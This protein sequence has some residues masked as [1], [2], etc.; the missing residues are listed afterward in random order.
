MIDEVEFEMLIINKAIEK[1]IPDI[2]DKE[3]GYV[4]EKGKKLIKLFKELEGKGY[5]KAFTRQEANELRMK[6]AQA[7]FNLNE[8]KELYLTLYKLLMNNQKNVKDTKN[9]LKDGN[10]QEYSITMN[11]IAIIWGMTYCNFYESIRKWVEG[12]INLKTLP[13]K[14]VTGLGSLINRLKTNSIQNISFFDDLDPSARNAFSH[15]DFR[16][17]EE[18]RI[19]FKHEQKYYKNNE[20]RTPKQKDQEEF[21]SIA[22]LLNLVRIGDRSLFTV[23]CGCEYL[24]TKQQILK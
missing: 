11:Q 23:V 1:I 19:Y 15:L 21:I 7:I 10:G 6:T 17:G 5:I 4:I 8:M 9:V 13:G 16:F 3:R 24:I 22:D 14:R 20:W 18:G 2:T 12:V